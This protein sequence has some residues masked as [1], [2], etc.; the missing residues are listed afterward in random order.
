VLLSLLP[1]SVAVSADGVVLDG[2]SVTLLLRTT[3]ATACCPGCGRPSHHVHSRYNRT[4]RDLPLQNRQTVLSLTARKFFCRNTDCPRAVFCER[5]PD[6]A[7]PH[8]QSSP[9]LTDA[10]RAIAFALGGEPG[11]R[12]AGTLAMTTSADTLLRR[13]KQTPTVEPPAPRVLGVDDWAMHKGLS[14]GTILVDLERGAVIDLMPG[15]DGAA[16]RQ[17]LSDH[18]GVELISRD[19]ASAYAQAATEAAPDAVQVADRWHLLKNVRETLE[20][21][22]ERHRGEIQA[23]A[24]ALAQPLAPSDNPLEQPTQEPAKRQAVEAAQT[25]TTPPESECEQT[26]REQAQ[27]AKRQQRVERYQEVRQRHGEGQSIRRIAQETGLSRGAVRRYLRQEHCPD[28]RPGQARRSRLD[29]FCK[30]IDEQILA[31][32]D[33]C[34]ELHRDLAAK[35]YRGSGESVRRFVTKRLAALGKQRQRANAAK[36]RSP[37]AP[38]ARSLAYDVLRRQDK[39]TD[40]GRARLDVLRGISERFRETLA[41]MEEFSA[42]IRKERDETL[43]DW[44]SRAE[45]AASAEVKGFAQGIRQDE[46]AVAAGMTESWSNGPVEGQVN[47]LKTIKRQMYGRAGFGLLRRRVLQAN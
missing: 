14:Y 38:S 26:P 13:I 11:A 37:P 6:L 23:V 47:R 24:G 28:W 10:H 21:F 43:A 36:P 7:A 33:N 16:L 42:L 19:R 25:T 17:W 8:A 9:R 40:D 5:L 18:P 1:A 3:S 32:R 20:R 46:S 30:W 2:A 39:Q 41:L 22:F 29:G 12:L 15:R 44:L 4:V 31:G 34:T 35:G 27:Q 45:R